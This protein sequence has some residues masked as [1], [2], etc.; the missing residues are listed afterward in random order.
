MMIYRFDF[1]RHNNLGYDVLTMNVTEG[2]IE[3]VAYKLD[4]EGDITGE[5]LDAALSGKHFTKFEESTYTLDDLRS[6]VR[7]SDMSCFGLSPVFKHYPYWVDINR[8]TRS[9][10]AFP[11]LLNQGCPVKIVFP[12]T[13]STFLDCIIS[14]PRS[15]ADEPFTVLSNLPD[16]QFISEE[17]E[18]RGGEISSGLPHLTLSGPTEVKADTGV[19]LSLVVAESDLAL[20]SLY[21]ITLDSDGG[22]IPKRRIRLFTGDSA[23]VKVQAQ[24]LDAG[25]VITVTAS[26]NGYGPVA[27]WK[28][29]VT[30]GQEA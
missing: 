19:V 28:L 27:S 4:E 20:E 13:E 7:F 9:S 25:D 29:N 6:H 30:A 17:E 8:E 26:M 15:F 12:D 3:L 16:T 14:V 5:H 22:Y 10:K 24:G 18:V 11:E 21:D 1:A 23:E 2:E